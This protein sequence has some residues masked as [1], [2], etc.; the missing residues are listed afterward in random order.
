MTNVWMT[1]HSSPWAAAKASFRWDLW[2][3]GTSCPKLRSQ[4]QAPSQSAFVTGLHGF[5]SLY[6]SNLLRS[7]YL[8]D[9]VVVT[10]ELFV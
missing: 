1:G 10:E 5:P 2:N 7:F 6:F 8:G 3:A 4:A 9:G